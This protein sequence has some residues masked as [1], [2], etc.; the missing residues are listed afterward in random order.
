[1]ASCCFALR[2][3][4]HFLFIVW[5]FPQKQFKRYVQT[6]TQSSQFS[7]FSYSFNRCTNFYFTQVPLS[8]THNGRIFFALRDNSQV[9]HSFLFFWGAGTESPQM[10]SRGLALSRWISCQVV[11]SVTR[12]R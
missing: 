10:F 1:M 2:R 9:S 12:N 3:E 6:L 8:S 4:I 5:N 7:Y 11:D